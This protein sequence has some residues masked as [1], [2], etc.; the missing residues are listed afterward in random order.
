MEE[1][2]KKKNLI[3]MNLKQISDIDNQIK[4]KNLQYV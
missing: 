2:Y 4:Q 3:V 1:H